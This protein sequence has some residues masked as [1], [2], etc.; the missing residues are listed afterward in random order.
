V[1]QIAEKKK[2]EKA[3]DPTIN[4]AEAPAIEDA[5]DGGENHLVEGYEDNPDAPE[6]SVAQVQVLKDRVSEE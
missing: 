4:S 5:T 3:E 2:S 6:G 1:S